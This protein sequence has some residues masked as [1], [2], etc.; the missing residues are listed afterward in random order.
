LGKTLTRSYKQS[1][2]EHDV[3]QE[4]H[5]KKGQK[6]GDE[7]NPE[8][9]KSYFGN[10]SEK[11]KQTVTFLIFAADVTL[12]VYSAFIFSIDEVKEDI[13]HT[14]VRHVRVCKPSAYFHTSAWHAA[15]QD[16]Q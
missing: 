8:N 12:Q 9:M 10:V 1:Y 14:T 16:S 11:K 3:K 4:K 5:T 2:Q 15:K 7:I 6:N 13:S